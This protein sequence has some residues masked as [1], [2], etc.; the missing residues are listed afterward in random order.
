MI[1]ARWIQVLREPDSDAA[2]FPDRQ[3]DQRRGGVRI[4]FVAVPG[5]PLSAA[6]HANGTLAATARAII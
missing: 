1:W 5:V 6:T 2:D 4:L 3:A